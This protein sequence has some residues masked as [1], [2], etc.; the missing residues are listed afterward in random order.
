MRERVR[1]FDGK[2]V[3]SSKEGKGTKLTFFIPK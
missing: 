1:Q 3:V 2:F